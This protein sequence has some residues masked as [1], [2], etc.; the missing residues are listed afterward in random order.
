MTTGLFGD[1]YKYTM[2]Q[3]WLKEGMA[4]DRVTYDYFTRNVDKRN[5]FLVAG[6]EPLLEKIQNFK[7]TGEQLDYLRKRG[8]D[9]QLVKYLK[10]FKFIGD[11]WGMPEGTVAFANEPILRVSGPRI[12][13]SIIET[14]IENTLNCHTMLASKAARI[15]KAA[16]GKAVVDFSPRRDHEHDAA[17]AAARASYIAGVVGTSLEEAGEKYGI[18]TFGTMGH[19]WI[20]SFKTELEAFR[21][22][23]RQWPNDSTFLIDTYDTLQGARN[24]VIVAKELE[25]KGYQLRSVR[26]DSGDFLDLSK[27][28]RTIFDE[29]GLQYV[30][31]TASGDLNEYKIRDLLEKN[32]A[33]DVFGVGTEMGVSKDAPALPGVYKL[34]QD[35]MLGPRLKLSNDKVKITLPG[36]K[37]VYRVAAV[38]GKFIKDVIAL[39]DEIVHGQP[40][41]E[42]YVE[43]GSICRK[44]TLEQIRERAA[45]NLSNLPDKFHSIDDKFGYPVT[46]DASL[47]AVVED[48]RKQYMTQEV[49]A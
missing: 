6:I 25:E 35:E 32:A 18:P 46:L 13:T 30:K 12:E 33:I 1:K 44:E 9:E 38:N 11:I 48:L 36:V 34:A 43:N 41:L 16:N 8:Y 14:I 10:D 15:V 23:A 29:R 28:V 19:E 39:E 21:A 47:N 3:A 5:Y 7:F 20:M 17:I 49:G 4:Q 24:T 26:L 42:K 45:T 27:K 2:A 40:L 22:Y 31:I 37:Q